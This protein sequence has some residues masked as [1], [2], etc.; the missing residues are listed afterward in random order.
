MLG[1]E[2]GGGRGREGGKGRQRETERRGKT[3]RDAE[4]FKPR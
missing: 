4:I 1:L 2:W 3:D